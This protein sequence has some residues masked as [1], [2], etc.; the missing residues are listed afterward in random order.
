MTS[1]EYRLSGI[2]VEH[3][4]PVGKAVRPQPLIFVHGGC[5][6]SW[7]W[8]CFLPF[9]AEAGWDC[10]ALNWYNHNGSDPHPTQ[11]LVNRGIADV[12]EEIALVADQFDTPP[13]L[14]GH[15]MGGMAAQKYA[16]SHTV[17]ALVLVT[18]VVPAPVAGDPIELPVDMEQPWSPPP[19]HIARDLFF[20]G[21]S[22]EDAN[23]YYTLMCQESP[24]CVYEATRWTVP[25]D[26]ITISDP[27]LVVA[28]AIDILTPPSTGRALADFYG[29]DYRC[30]RGR[31]HNVPLEPGWR[32]TAG[33]I[34]QWL[35]RQ[36]DERPL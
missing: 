35:L 25:I 11:A 9:F 34:A 4:S 23:H 17:S 3:A 18:P 10:H 21:S 7:T 20:Q 31:G 14:I 19:F 33:M 32:E 6:G 15:S 26:K 13:I 16:E 22:Y 24:R 36:L 2:R 30:L 1:G 12:T 5:G 8:K 29:A 27:I 28:G